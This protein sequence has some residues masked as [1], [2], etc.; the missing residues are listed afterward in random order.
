MT[1][2]SRKRTTMKWLFVGAVLALVIGTQPAYA[3][4]DLIPLEQ[5]N[6]G[7]KPL[8]VAASPD[9]KLVFVLAPGEIVVYSIP[10]KAVTNRIRLTGSFD[11]VTYSANADTLI[12]SSSTSGALKTIKVEPVFPIDISNHPFEGPANAPVTLVVFDDYQ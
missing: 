1:A 9:G 5:T 8:D 12:L 11:R 3:K 6:L 4:V 2:E 10:E 7:V